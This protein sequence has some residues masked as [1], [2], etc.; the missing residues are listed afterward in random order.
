M[1]G[2]L[3]FT[4]EKGRFLNST[5]STDVM[6]VINV[7]NFST[8]ARRLKLDFTDLYKKG[9]SF[10]KVSAQFSLDQ[11]KVT[12]D[13]PLVMDGPSGR[14]ELKG[15]IDSVQNAIDASLIVTIPVNKNATWIAALAA[16]LPVAAGVWAVSKIFGDQIDKLS[17][18][19][20]SISGSLDDP[21]VKFESLLPELS[22]GAKDKN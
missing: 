19:N 14:F 22:K 11:G 20:Y 18:V 1:Q 16:G 8:W 7:F 4:S 5:A 2:D 13:K 15:T 21:Q 9:V 6:R 10:D 12:F 17:S 3:S